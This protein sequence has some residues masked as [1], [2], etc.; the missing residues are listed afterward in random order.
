[1][2]DDIYQKKKKKLKCQRYVQKKNAKKMQKKCKKK[3]NSYHNSR[4]FLK[5]TT[6]PFFC[7]HC[8]GSVVK[9]LS[10]ARSISSELDTAANPDKFLIP[11]C[12]ISRTEKKGKQRKKKFENIFHIISQ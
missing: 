5:T 1:M 10:L 2:Y 7:S 11:L 6:S 3:K 4:N 12:E 8:L 9:R